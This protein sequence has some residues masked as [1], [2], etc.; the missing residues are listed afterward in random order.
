MKKTM[1]ISS[2]FSK[3][4]SKNEVLT[5]LDKELKEYKIIDFDNLKIEYKNLIYIVEIVLSRGSYEIFIVED[6]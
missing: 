3:Y 2:F 4:P 5:C 6:K 1:S